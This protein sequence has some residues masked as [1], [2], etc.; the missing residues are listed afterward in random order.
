MAGREVYLQQS[1]NVLIKQSKNKATLWQVLIA[2]SS[3]LASASVYALVAHTLGP[4]NFGTYMFVRWLAIIAVPV[5]GIGMSPLTSRQ[6]ADIQSREAPRLSAGI[7][8]FL[9]YRQFRCMIIYG[10][11]SLVLAFPLAQMFGLHSPLLLLL[12]ILSTLPLL[13]SNIAGIALRS[14]RRTDL[15]ATLHLFGTL[16]TL[17]FIIVVRQ[18]GSSEISV[19]LLASTLADTLTLFLALICV[20]RL[21][22]MREARQPGIFLQERLKQSLKHPLHLFLLDVIIWQRSELFLLA[23]WYQPGELGFYTLSIMIS[24]TVI[25]VVP[26]LLSTGLLPF[27]LR[28]MPAHHY[29]NPYDAFIKTSCY[30]VFLAVPICLLLI[31]FCPIFITFF[32]GSAYLPTIL[33]LRILLIAAVFGSVATISITRMANSGRQGKQVAYGVGVAAL[34][35]VLSWIG[36]THWGLLGAALASALAQTISALGSIYICRNLLIRHEPGLSKDGL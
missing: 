29:R 15:L 33:P 2:T 26:T 14:L 16:T 25:S 18:I 27:L 36:I 13:L 20:M 17:L 3:A 9:W 32:L 28:Y 22:P 21:L 10:L 31:I 24:S 12:A 19:F 30:I 5:L 23:L 6:L 4:Q 34:K 11:F 1:R 8:Y 35:I 7:F